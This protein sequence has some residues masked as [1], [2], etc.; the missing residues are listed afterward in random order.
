VI[1][2]IDERRLEFHE[3]IEMLVYG[4]DRSAF[5]RREDLE[6]YKGVFGVSDMVDNLHML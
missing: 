5:Q 4:I 3:G 6:G 1:G 2:D